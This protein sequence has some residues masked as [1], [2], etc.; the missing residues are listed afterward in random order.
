MSDDLCKHDLDPR[1]CGVCKKATPTSRTVRDGE[2]DWRGTGA[3]TTA[4]Y[5]STCGACGDR[6]EPGQTIRLEQRG[7]DRRWVCC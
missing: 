7:D 1:W 3:S 6:I 2:D 5:E 4:V